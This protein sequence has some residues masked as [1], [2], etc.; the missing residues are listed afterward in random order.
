MRDIIDPWGSF[1]NT[2]P[3]TVSH[4]IH[5][6]FHL[7]V[8]C[9]LPC[10]GPILTAQCVL[11]TLSIV[12]GIPITGLAAF[13][14]RRCGIRPVLIII[15]LVDYLI[16]IQSPNGQEV[17]WLALP[18]AGRPNLCR[19]I[20]AAVLRI[21]IA[22]AFNPSRAGCLRRGAIHLIPQVTGVVPPQIAHWVAGIL[23]HLPHIC[24]EGCPPLP[25]R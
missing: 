19:E 21:M 17:T 15:I 18:A 14:A 5:L 25:K 2:F 23:K 11:L 24:A 10:P 7:P 16:L 22:G 9:S 4:P 6:P 3:F 12:I 13:I 8:L 1:N 20:I